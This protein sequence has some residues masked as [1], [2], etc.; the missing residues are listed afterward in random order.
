MDS[1]VGRRKLDFIT[2]SP[3]GTGIGASKRDRQNWVDSGSGATPS[4]MR[5][6]SNTDEPSQDTWER[7]PIRGGLPSCHAPLNQ[8]QVCEYQATCIVLWVRMT[9]ASNPLPARSSIVPSAI[10]Y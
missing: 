1:R 10:A 9:A 4:K 3:P 5:A 7:G 6:P 2:E 8:F